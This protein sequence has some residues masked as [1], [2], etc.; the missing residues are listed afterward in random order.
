MDP[1]PLGS[2]IADYEGQAEALRAAAASPDDPRLALA[3]WYGFLDRPSFVQWLEA[4]SRPDSEVGRFER[5]VESVV[6]GDLATLSQLLAEHPELVRARSTIITSTDQPRHRATLLHYVA[7]NGVEGWRQR[8][9]PNAVEIATRLLGAGAEPDALADMYG[10]RHTTLTMLVSSVHP[11]TAGLQVA[12]AGRCSTTAPP[13]TAPVW[14]RPRH[15][16]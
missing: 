5:A 8:T 14:A 9:P 7:A 10:G 13:S 2:P 12:L 15:H 3:R 16:S 11:A 1:L 6:S 4:V